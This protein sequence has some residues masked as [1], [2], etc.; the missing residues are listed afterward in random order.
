MK[1]SIII[2]IDGASWNVLNI[3]RE[4]RAIPAISDLIQNGV[5]GSLKSTIPYFTG[6]AW[7]SFATGR[8]PSEHSIYDFLRVDMERKKVRVVNSG[9]IRSKTYYELLNSNGLKTIIINLPVS[10]PPRY[11]CGIIISCFLTMDKDRMVS[12]LKIKERYPDMFSRYKTFP[13]GKI[14]DISNYINEL[15]YME[16]TRFELAK[17]LFAEEEWDHFFL[18]FSGTDWL[19]HATLG[20]FFD[21]DITI[22]Q[23]FIN[24][25]QEIDRYISWF[26]DRLDRG[27]TCFIISDH[28]SIPKRFIFNINRFLY[29]MGFATKRINHTVKDNDN[30]KDND[31]LPTIINNVE[32]QKK[33]YHIPVRLSVVRRNRYL[34][35]IASK[36]N[37]FLIR[38]LN[39]YIRDENSRSYVDIYKSLVF[40]PSVSSAGVYIKRN[41]NYNEIRDMVIDKLT[42]IENPYTG[43]RV[44]L[45]VWKREELHKGTYMEFAPDI[46]FVPVDGVA[47]VTEIRE[48]ESVVE[49]VSDGSGCHNSEG[50]FLAYGPGIKKSKEV[51][52]AGIADIFPTLFYSMDQS[53]PEGLDGRLLSDIF[54]EDYLKKNIPRYK[55]ISLN[56]EERIEEESNEEEVKRRLKGLGYI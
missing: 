48:R 18:L 32:T 42:S 11:D 43:G 5:Y 23:R 3:L 4:E 22:K 19:S 35:Y 15:S 30:D 51:Y 7:V 50:I 2:G 33:G 54:E 13:E 49:K 40:S 52:N 38:Y 21:G 39:I 14:E 34:R 26:L 24:F 6:P 17:R 1:R 41:D 45:N 36:I 47:C 55:I 9:D 53:I 27:T 16:E 8:R 12:P 20:R 46:I 28:G 31:L 10:Y 44:I 29:E 25:W 56:N 37:L